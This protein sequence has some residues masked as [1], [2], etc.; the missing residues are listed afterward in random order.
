MN[1]NSRYRIHWCITVVAIF[2]ISSHLHEWWCHHSAY[3][4]P[5]H[6]AINLVTT[7]VGPICFL[8][9]WRKRPVTAFS[10]VGF[11]FAAVS[12]FN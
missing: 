6:A 12:S 4:I 8:A 3:W 5:H 11:S 9:G 7:F 2:S 1:E 10:F